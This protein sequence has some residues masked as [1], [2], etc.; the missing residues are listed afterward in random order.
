MN[1]SLDKYHFKQ[2]RK[3]TMSNIIVKL[4]TLMRKCVWGQLHTCVNA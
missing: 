4:E 2:I 3:H 1:F